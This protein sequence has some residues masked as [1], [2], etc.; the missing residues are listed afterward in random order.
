MDTRFVKVGRTWCVI[1][2]KG[3]SGKISVTKSDG[4]EGEAT[5]LHCVGNLG[6]GTLYELAPREKRAKRGDTDPR[7][8]LDEGPRS[9]VQGKGRKVTQGAPAPVKATQGVDQAAIV[10][11]LLAALQGAP[12]G[13]K[14]AF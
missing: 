7:E 4:S 12:K 9:V 13:V 1:G 14:G 8:A 11:A 2:D 5:I 10:A 6:E 3:L